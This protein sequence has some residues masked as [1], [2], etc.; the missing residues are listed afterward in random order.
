M[1][2]KNVSAAPAETAESA[3]VAPVKAK[4]AAPAKYT[5]A[6]LVAAAASVFPKTHRD[7]VAAA[8]RMDGRGQYTKAEAQAIVTA[9]ATRPIPSNTTKKEGK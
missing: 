1:A 7:I 3:P 4:E 6:E 5:T 2:N 9:F 8:L